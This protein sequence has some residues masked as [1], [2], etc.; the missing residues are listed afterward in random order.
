MIAIYWSNGRAARARLELNHDRPPKCRGISGND[1]AHEK[2]LA[3]FTK[4]RVELG[5]FAPL[6]RRNGS[7]LIRKRPAVIGGQALMRFST[8]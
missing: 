8:R 4:V 2:A 3:E 7:N 5:L 6:F 1:T